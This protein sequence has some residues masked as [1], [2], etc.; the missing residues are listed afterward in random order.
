MSL[1]AT[2]SQTVGPYL[3]IGLIW[4]IIENLAPAGVDVGRP[5][6]MAQSSRVQEKR[7][8]RRV[9]VALTGHCR[10]GNRFARNPV[11]D[12][13]AGGL[14]LK[15][16]EPAANG[17]PVRVAIALPYSDGPR[18]CTLAGCVVRVDRDEKGHLC[19]I[20]VSFSEEQIATMDRDVLEKFL[21]GK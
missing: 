10:I 2:T 17:A 5:L 16:R 13:S 4:L 9:S 15:T 1:Q 14:Y 8:A 6:E 7:R 20:G 11:A 21:A 3:H 12:L 18:F 19:G